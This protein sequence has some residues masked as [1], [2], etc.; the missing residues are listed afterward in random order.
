MRLDLLRSLLPSLYD[1]L[2]ST[3]T[4][5]VEVKDESGEVVAEVEKLLHVKKKVRSLEL[6]RT[7]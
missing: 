2:I 4:Y 5:T 3:L 7:A 6:S 1:R